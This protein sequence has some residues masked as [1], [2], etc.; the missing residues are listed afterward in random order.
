MEKGKNKK[1]VITSGSDQLVVVVVVV[2]TV[3]GKKLINL[4]QNLIYLH[5]FKRNYLSI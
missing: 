3:H 1:I 5:L 2:I 4:C